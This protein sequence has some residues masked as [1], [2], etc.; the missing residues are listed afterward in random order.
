M[1]TLTGQMTTR[2]KGMPA[3]GRR[4]PVDPGQGIP[5][6]EWGGPAP[7]DQGR[8]ATAPG[9]TVHQGLPHNQGDEGPA[10]STRQRGVEGDPAWGLRL[11]GV[12]ATDG[13][14]NKVVQCRRHSESST[15]QT[16]CNG[17]G[18]KDCNS[19]PQGSVGGHVTGQIGFD[20]QAGSYA[21]DVMGL[22]GPQ[23]PPDRSR[24]PSQ[25]LGDHPTRSDGLTPVAPA[26][27]TSEWGAPA[28]TTS[29]WGAPAPIP[30]EWGTPISRGTGSGKPPLLSPQVVSGYYAGGVCYDNRRDWKA[31]LAR[32]RTLEADPSC[33][34]APVAQEATE[35]TKKIFEGCQRHQKFFCAQPESTGD[36]ETLNDTDPQGSE[37]GQTSP[38]VGVEPENPEYSNQGGSCAKGEPVLLSQDRRRSTQ[39]CGAPGGKNVPQLQG[40]HLG[41]APVGVVTQPARAGLSNCTPSQSWMD[42]DGTYGSLDPQD[43]LL[44][45]VPTPAERLQD[46]QHWRQWCDRWQGNLPPHLKKTSDGQYP[47]IPPRW[48]TREGPRAPPHD[49]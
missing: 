23:S 47:P 33:G 2:G 21:A 9:R 25:A 34:K 1:G 44:V 18:G 46:L 8:D 31:A 40:S 30:S 37:G 19:D 11:T 45:G 4:E 7:M 29:E 35:G 3:E 6:L 28:P 13:T 24:S 22:R 10:T 49:S 38:E 5:N 42:L 17:K 27:T 39:E 20:G 12:H 43:N 48:W 36:N 32:L 26:P 15:S 41:P 16:E 14:E